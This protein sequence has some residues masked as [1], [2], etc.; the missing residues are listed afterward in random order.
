MPPKQLRALILDAAGRSLPLIVVVLV[1]VAVV[2]VGSAAVACKYSSLN[3]HIGS[4]K[5]PSDARIL[6]RLQQQSQGSP[7]GHLPAGFRT[8]IVARGLALP[9]DFGFLP[10][11]AFLVGEKN[12]LLLRIAADGARHVVLDLRKKVDTHDYR[13]VIS[14]GVSPT[15]VRDRRI[16]VLYVVKS[17]GRAP[18]APTVAR[19]SSFRLPPGDRRA[20][21]ERVLVGSVTAPSCTPLPPTADCI[22]SDRD[23]DGGEMAFA[24]DGTIFLAT[25]DGGGYDENVEPGALAAQ[26]VD[27]LSG[28]ILHITKTGAGVPTNP[29][30]NGDARAN[31]SKVWAIGFRNPF[32]LSLRGG[33]GPP[34]VGDVGRYAFE[35]LDVVAKGGNYGWPCF[36]A[37]QRLALYASTAVCR[38]VYRRPA[39]ATLPPVVALPH[40]I[41]SSIV[42]GVFAPR[43]FPARYRGTFLFGDWGRGFIRYVSLNL[44]HPARAV[45]HVFGTKLPGPVALHLSPAGRLYYLA[46]NSSDLRRIDPPR[47]AG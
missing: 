40:T 30:W 8:Q 28:K 29:W 36:E 26:N 44:A 10:G 2:G 11:G 43:S 1:C 5:E 16:Y 15:F 6:K 35:E 42:A 34:I 47:P 7:K 21:D 38:A 25:G 45:S 18:A 13:G 24:S 31:R 17:P 23:H 33:S 9:T 46:L 3:C 12:G 14:V 39:S 32:R 22:P 19:F 4:T 27:S 37:D 41:S 20:G